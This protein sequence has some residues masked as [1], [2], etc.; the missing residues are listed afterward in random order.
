MATIGS[1]SVELGV[2]TKPD[3]LSAGST[4]ARALWMEVVE[5]K[6]HPLRH[7]YFCTRQPDDAERARDVTA[8]EN[9]ASEE[10]FF[11]TAHPW[12]DSPLRNRFGTK[13]L[14]GTLGR[15]LTIIITETSVH[16]FAWA[17]DMI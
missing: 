17:A 12:A 3:M 9:C 8:A 16:V 14:V 5:G 1:S 7:G 10:K 11:Q 13:N 4:K 2:L 6:N 15:L